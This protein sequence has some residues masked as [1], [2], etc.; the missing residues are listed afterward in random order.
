[1]K[2]N[3][4]RKLI[5]FNGPR[6]SGK[7]TA[8]IYCHQKYGAHHFKFSYPMKA[9]IKTMFSLSDEQVDYLETIKTEPSELLFGK[10]YVECQISLSEE[11]FKVKWNNKIFGM[12]AVN[13]LKGQINKN[14]EQ[15]F[16]V[17]SDSG[18][19]SEAYPVADLFGAENVLLVK[20]QRPGKTFDGD[21]RSYIELDNIKT[22]ELQNDKTEEEYKKAIDNV[23]NFWIK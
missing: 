5:L 21:S 20:I 13:Y 2:I 23:V 10:S 11:W 19:S 22:I 4:E 17:C 16:Y 3:N 9:G 7:D 6:H 12:L 8:S 15:N 14:P 1:M 18:F